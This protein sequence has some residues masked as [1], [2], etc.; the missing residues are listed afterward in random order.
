MGTPTV[1]LTAMSYTDLNLNTADSMLNL[2]TADD[3]LFDKSFQSFDRD[4]KSEYQRK[5]QNWRI[6]AGAIHD[7]IEFELETRW[8]PKA[9]KRVLSILGPLLLVITFLE[10]GLRVMTRWSEQMSYLTGT[11]HGMGFSSWFAVMA[12]VTSI[13]LQIGG[14]MLVLQGSNIPQLKGKHVQ[15]GGGALF[16]FLLLQPVMYGQHTDM[17]FMCRTLTLAGGLALL[18]QHDMQSNGAK[19][20]LFAGLPD[21]GTTS[22]NSQELVQLIGRTLITLI[23]FYQ[24][25]ENLAKAHAGVMHW[26]GAII[27]CAICAGVLLGFKAKAAG[28][29]LLVLL[30]VG[31][32]VMHP[33]WSVKPHMYDFTKFY[34]FQTLSVMGGLMLLILHG[35]GGLSVKLGSKKLM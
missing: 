13:V 29:L 2:N 10:D 19:A 6:D 18:W 7:R 21:A 9:M 15:I 31:N 4:L 8:S 22:Q 17:D 1:P 23:F 11:R 14:A 32:M 24:M 26:V 33:F 35:P 28:V 25:F 12:L 3:A 20:D 34:F 16:T 5:L 27:T 30:A